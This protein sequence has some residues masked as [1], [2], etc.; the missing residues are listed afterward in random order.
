MKVMITSTGVTT[1]DAMDPRFGRCSTFLLVDTEEETVQA[2]P[3]EAVTRGSGAGIQA[4]ETIVDLGAEA[5]ITGQVGPKAAQVLKAAGIPVYVGGSGTAREALEAFR[6]NRLNR[7]EESPP[8]AKM[9]RGRGGG[10][11][12]GKGRG[13]GPGPERK[14]G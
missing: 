4:A 6:E 13:P 11:G 1:E 10:M 14:S 5:V 8:R 7:L 3:N 2:I 12:Q 9:G